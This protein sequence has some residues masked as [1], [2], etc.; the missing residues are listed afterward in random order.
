MMTR[1]DYVVVAEILK[2]H[3]R[4]IPEATLESLIFDFNE[5]FLKDNP[6][7]DADRFTEAVNE[8]RHARL[9]T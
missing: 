4:Y 3:K 7:F 9:G 8:Q 5:M 1:K 6:R 2:D